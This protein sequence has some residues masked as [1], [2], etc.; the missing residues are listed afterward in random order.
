M[1]QGIGIIPLISSANLKNRIPPLEP[2]R[3][4]EMTHRSKELTMLIKHGLPI[5]GGVP[6]VTLEIPQ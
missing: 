1:S 4:L 5:W 2:T 6:A 3:W